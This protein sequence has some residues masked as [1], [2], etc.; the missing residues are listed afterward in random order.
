[1]PQFKH[2]FTPSGYNLLAKI[3]LG[4]VRSQKACFSV[5]QSNRVITLKKRWWIIRRCRLGE[6][7]DF[8]HQLQGWQPINV[9]LLC[10]EIKLT[11]DRMQNDRE[12]A[13]QPLWIAVILVRDYGLT[14]SSVDRFR[15]IP[16][17]TVQSASLEMHVK[18]F[19]AQDR[20]WTH[21]TYPV[22][23]KLDARMKES[24]GF[25]E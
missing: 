24:G 9:S 5:D 12:M 11:S 13:H 6:L 14:R 18:S 21:T 20:G 15:S 7:H 17:K 10:H 22:G 1:M 16:E 19:L 8:I 4:L 25:S 2:A 3:L 23:R